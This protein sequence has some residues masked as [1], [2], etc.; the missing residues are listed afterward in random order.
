M[1]ADPFA[2][3]RRT[4]E[5][6]FSNT[7]IGDQY[8]ADLVTVPGDH[9]KHP[10]RQP[11]VD[12]AGRH[13]APV[14][15]CRSTPPRSTCMVLLDDGVP[16]RAEL[17]IAVDVATRTICAAVLRPVG[18]KAVDA[19][20]L[21]A[22]ML[23]PEPMRPGWSAA[24]RD[25]GVAAAAR[26]AARHRRPDGA[27]RGPAGDRPGHHRH[28]PRARCSSPTTFTRA[29]ERLG[30]SVQPARPAPRPTRRSSSDLRLDQHAVL[31]ARRRLHR[32]ERHPPRPPTSSRPPGRCRS[33]R[34]CSTSG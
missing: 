29:C 24:L 22:R 15:R 20:L 3:V 8:V 26:P 1:S 33:C 11:G 27:G 30:I 25:V 13:A 12:E 16:V 19:A 34:T 4:G 2:D 32:P 9:R 6:D 23:V 18:T 31:P 7:S 14:S 28:R 21:L 17:T 5:R 10:R